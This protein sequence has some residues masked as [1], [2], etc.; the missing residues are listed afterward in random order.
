MAF[1]SCKNLPQKINY[2]IYDKKLLAIIKSFEERRPML[3]EAGLPIKIL[4]DHRNLQYFMSTKQLSRRQA[5]WSEFL[6]HFNFVI[7]YRLGKLEAKPDALTRRS[8]NLFK[9]EDSHLQQM[10]QT[11]LKP[12]T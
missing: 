4:I 8:R 5:R 6:L 3:E 12:K 9:E 11:V 7:Q 2:D 1:F 10:V